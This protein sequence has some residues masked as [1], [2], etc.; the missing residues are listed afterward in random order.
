MKTWISATLIIALLVFAGIAVVKAI[1]S[2]P[3]EK[4]ST[5]CGASCSNSCTAEKNCGS[6]TCKAVSGTGTCGCGK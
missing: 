3:V 2:E 4:T 1:N 6:P 5:G